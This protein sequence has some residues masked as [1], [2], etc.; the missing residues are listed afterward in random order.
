MSFSVSQVPGLTSDPFHDASTINSNVLSANKSNPA[1]VNYNIQRS[2][3]QRRRAARNSMLNRPMG[4][5][6]IGS[7]P[8]FGGSNA[9]NQSL[10][11]KKDSV[12]TDLSHLPLSTSSPIDLAQQ[13]VKAQIEKD[14]STPTLYEV[15]SAYVV[16]NYN[17]NPNQT[18]KSV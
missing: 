18:K 6:Y 1:T 5:S 8:F 4:N 17:F 11:N 10:I 3:I 7:F 13:C 14:N 9:N 2:E 15:F 12:V 16:D